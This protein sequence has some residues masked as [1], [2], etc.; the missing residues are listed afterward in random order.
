MAKPEGPRRTSRLGC[1]A[2]AERLHPRPPRC[3]PP[4]GSGRVLGLLAA[5]AILSAGCA[6]INDHEPPYT[7]CSDFLVAPL[8]V[9]GAGFHGSVL[10]VP[11]L[12]PRGFQPG[13]VTFSAPPE[14]AD[15]ATVSE[16]FVVRLYNFFGWA[17]RWIINLD[18]VDTHGM[19]TEE[20]VRLAVAPGKHTVTLRWWGG[21]WPG[22]HE[23]TQ[24]LTTEPSEKYFFVVKPS[25]KGARIDPVEAEVGA[26][27]IAGSR[28][29]F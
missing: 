14:V 27:E 29:L 12:I 7:A 5:L 2:D 13:G 1:T 20:Y 18:G 25:L 21:W 15:A 4:V 6:T 8:G 17:S 28:R 22:W 19:C 16:I 24:V 23:D 26:K 11:V 3:R 10:I 9:P